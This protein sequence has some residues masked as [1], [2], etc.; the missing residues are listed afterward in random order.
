MKVASWIVAAA[1]I[2]VILLAVYGRFHTAPVIT[3]G[4][5]QYTASTFLLVGNTLL[6]ISVFLGMLGFQT[7][8]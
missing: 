1:G 4:A 8:K 7:K 2:V 5:R 3:I 6:L